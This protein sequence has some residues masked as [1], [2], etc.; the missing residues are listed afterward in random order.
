VKDNTLFSTGT[1][2]NGAGEFVFS[3]RTGGGTM[4]RA[5]LAF[6]VAGALPAGAKITEASLTLSLVQTNSGPQAHSLHRV[7]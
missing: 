5:V 7:L 6:D 3:G 1:T 2:S 4:Q